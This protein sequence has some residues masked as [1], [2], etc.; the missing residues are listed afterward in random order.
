MS[1]VNFK[2]LF[3]LL[4]TAFIIM[5]VLLFLLV[6]MSQKANITTTIILIVVPLAITYIFY[7]L[8]GL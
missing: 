4:F 6:S 1:Q 5:V 2:K 3:G 7:K 8:A